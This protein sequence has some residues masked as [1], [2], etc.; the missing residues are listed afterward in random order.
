[1]RYKC[2]NTYPCRFH[3]NTGEGDR[4]WNTTKIPTRIQ[5]ILVTGGAGA[6][7]GN[8]CRGTLHPRAKKLSFSII[9]V[10]LMSGIFPRLKTFSFVK[11]DILDDES[12]KRVFKEKPSMSLPP[13]CHF[14]NQ[15]SVDNP[16]PT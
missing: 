13:R 12:L 10:R 5:T 11:G 8:H 4:T 9:S 1:M 15:N 2:D 7:G 16:R 3:K 14:A 6:I